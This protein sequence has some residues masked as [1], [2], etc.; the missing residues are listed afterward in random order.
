M[1]KPVPSKHLN[2]A[3]VYRPDDDL[4]ERAQAAVSDVGSNMNAHIIEF[5]HWLVGDT[6]TPPA[7][8]DTPVPHPQ[9]K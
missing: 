3:R 7:R 8:P 4:Y 1:L 5:L 9:P 6:D 2:R